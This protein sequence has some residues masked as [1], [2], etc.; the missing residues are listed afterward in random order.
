MKDKTLLRT[1]L[2][3][4]VVFALCC[5]TPVLAILLGVVGL[6]MLVGWLDFVLLPALAVFVGI[7]IYAL[8]K[9]KR[10]T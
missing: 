1:G 2:I 5:F 4:T 10:T 6:S 9:T 3:G 7:T 8:W